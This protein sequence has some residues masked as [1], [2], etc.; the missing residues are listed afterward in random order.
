MRPPTLKLEERRIMHCCLI[1]LAG[2]LRDQ[3]AHHLK[4]AE[5]LDGD[6]LQHVADR[7]VLDVERLNPIL[8]RC[9]LLSG[10][11]AELL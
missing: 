5:L 2:V 7:G 9:R 11:T 4:V 10:R 8:E 3:L 6:V 1:N